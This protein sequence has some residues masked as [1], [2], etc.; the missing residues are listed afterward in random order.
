MLLLLRP[1]PLLLLLELFFWNAK[2]TM[3]WGGGERQRGGEG[4][5]AWG[6]VRDRRRNRLFERQVREQ[7]SQGKEGEEQEEFRGGEGGNRRGRGDA[8]AA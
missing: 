7:G 5:K 6:R 3:R 8:A 1:L 2:A 4:G